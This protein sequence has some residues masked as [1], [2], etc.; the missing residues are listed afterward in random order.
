MEINGIENTEELKDF[1]EGANYAAQE[2]PYE[3]NSLKRNNR[4]PYLLAV[5]PVI[6]PILISLVNHLNILAIQGKEGMKNHLEGSPYCY[7]IALEGDRKEESGDGLGAGLKYLIAGGG[8]ILNDATL[9]LNI[10]GGRSIGEI[11]CGAPVEPE[12]SNL[13]KKN[14]EKGITWIKPIEIFESDLKSIESNRLVG[15]EHIKLNLKVISDFPEGKNP[16]YKDGTGRFMVDSITPL[17]AVSDGDVVDYLGNLYLVRG[18]DSEYYAIPIDPSIAFIA[19]IANETFIEKDVFSGIKIY[20]LN[21][22]KIGFSFDSILANSIN[23]APDKL[24]QTIAVSTYSSFKSGATPS[25]FIPSGKFYDH[26]G[27]EYEAGAIASTASFL[28]SYTNEEGAAINDMVSGKYVQ[29]NRDKFD[30]AFPFTWSLISDGENLVKDG[31][32]SELMYL[33]QHITSGIE[34]SSDSPLSGLVFFKTEEGVFLAQVPPLIIAD[35]RSLNLL[36]ERIEGKWGKVIQLALPDLH[37]SAIEE[38]YRSGLQNYPNEGFVNS[39]I[40][41]PSLLINVYKK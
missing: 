9:N 25:D 35:A 28:V 39:N 18:G 31:W 32:Q 19:G 27:T 30:I 10:A 2:T 26:I 20:D 40:S 22:L 7:Y 12:V 37:L 14:I 5:A 21:N 6:V 36:L 1:V 23:S 29:E 33:R 34:G 3:E 15:E 41:L 24:M 8:S 4:I 17:W 11:I 16:F 38:A 13:G